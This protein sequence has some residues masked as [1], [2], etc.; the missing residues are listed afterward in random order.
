MIG[1]DIRMGPS[2]VRDIA[3]GVALIETLGI[4]RSFGCRS[5][6]DNIVIRPHNSVASADFKDFRGEL[7]FFDV[8]GVS[9]S[10]SLLTAL[11]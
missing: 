2:L 5:M 11:R 8:D 10:F 1:A 3:P 9:L 6:R 7:K 4:E